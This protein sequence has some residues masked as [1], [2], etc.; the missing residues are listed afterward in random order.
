[1]K[2]LRTESKKYYLFFNIPIQIISVISLFYITNW[3]IF[4]VT[5]F[6]SYIIVYWLGIQ[7]G[8]HKLFAHKTW[9]PKNNFVRYSVAVI[10]CFGLMGGPI[11]WAQIHRNH[12]MHSDTEKD[13]HSPKFGMLNSYFL[14]LF[15]L[16]ELNL[17]IVKDLLKN[18][19]LIFINKHCKEI[20][21][22]TLFLFLTLN[23]NIFS[24]IIMSCVLTFH[25]EMFVNS[26][27]H[28]LVNNKWQ[29][30]NNTL[31]SI[32]TGGSTLH[33]NHHDNIKLNNFAIK[34]YEFDGSYIFIK[35]LSK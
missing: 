27:L 32:I 26:F 11:T 31:L 28:K 20:V 13:L 15:N 7:A 34:K 29:P 10:S 6:I 21:L 4:F 18:N 22:T 1:M 16:P 8:S 5:L 14:W 25:S 35:I 2:T 12:H 9:E 17:I 24:G 19:K 30:I 3:V 23:F 33:K